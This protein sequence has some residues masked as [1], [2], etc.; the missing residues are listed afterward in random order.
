[1]SDAGY[2]TE[3]ALLA[4]RVDL[5]SDILVKGQ[6]R[7]GSSG[8]DAFLDAVRPRLIIATSRDFL[9]QER[10]S[11][12]W[13]ADVRARGIRLFRQDEVGAVELEFDPDGWRAR[14]FVTGETFR[15]VSR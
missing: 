2:A 1:L 8:S 7:S 5:R 11:D 3:K 9:Q 6:H 12:E 10:I 14:A 15:N 13:A 4:S